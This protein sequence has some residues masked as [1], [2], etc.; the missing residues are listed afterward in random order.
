[1]DRGQTVELKLRFDDVLVWRVDVTVEI[2]Q[3]FCDGLL[4]TQAKP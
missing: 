3:R 4:W 2:K 1:M